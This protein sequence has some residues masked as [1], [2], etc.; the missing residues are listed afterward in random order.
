MRKPQD[1]QDPETGEA[2]AAAAKRIDELEIKMAFLE[3]ELDEYKEASRNFY[4]KLNQLEEDMRKMEKE[5]PGTNLPTPEASWD[6]ENRE[7]RT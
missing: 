6:S 2:A 1:V 7:V 4:S 3:K 5:I